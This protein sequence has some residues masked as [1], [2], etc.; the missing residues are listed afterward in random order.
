MKSTFEQQNHELQ[1]GFDWSFPYMAKKERAD[2][3]FST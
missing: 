2:Q 3:V 1:D